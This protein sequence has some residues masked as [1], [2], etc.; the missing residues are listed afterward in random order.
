MTFRLV[1]GTA[2]AIATNRLQS[3]AIAAISGTSA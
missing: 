2:V 1:L 3:T